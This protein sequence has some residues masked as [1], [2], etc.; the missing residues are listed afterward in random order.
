MSALFK[1]KETEVV[2]YEPSIEDV[3]NINKIE[4]FLKSENI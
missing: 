1:V 4:D 3:D 2:T